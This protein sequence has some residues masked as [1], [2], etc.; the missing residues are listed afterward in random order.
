[1]R[2][3]GCYA[4]V[5]VLRH[6]EVGAAVLAARHSRKPVINA[7]DGVGEHPTQALLDAF[8]IHE[9]LGRLDGLTVTLLGDLKFG[10]TVH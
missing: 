2:T 5:I 4:D 9:E 1:M 3:L 7:G 8:T 10:R 6:P